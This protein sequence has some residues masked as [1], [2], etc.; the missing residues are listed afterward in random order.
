MTAVLITRIVTTTTTTTTVITLESQIEQEVTII[1]I[2]ALKT[3]LHR[4]L[5]RCEIIN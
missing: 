5:A 2:V 4:I 1:M 3:G